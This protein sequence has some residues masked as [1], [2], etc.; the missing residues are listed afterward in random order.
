MAIDTIKKAPAAPDTFE[1]HNPADGSLIEAVPVD[2]S[3][4]VAEVVARLR[5]NQPAWEALGIGR[6][7]HWLGK[8]RDWLIDNQ[9]QIAATMQRETGKVWA[10]ASAEV[11]Y[12]CDLVNYYGK[13]ARKF[14]G[15]QR[16]A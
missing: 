16:V 15:D 3:E 7:A 8:L 2:G 1:V 12:V 13:S 10:E 6:R 5:A 14:I 11:P 9:D 4:R